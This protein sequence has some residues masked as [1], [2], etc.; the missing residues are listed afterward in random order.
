MKLETFRQATTEVFVTHSDCSV[1]VTHWANLEG[2]NFMFH[3]KDLALRCAGSFTWPELDMLLV[4]FTA[5]RT[6]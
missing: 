1:T 5:A 6:V 4:A 3:G 2:V